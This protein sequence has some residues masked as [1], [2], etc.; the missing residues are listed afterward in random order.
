[1]V[2]NFIVR[3]FKCS[4]TKMKGMAG[5]VSQVLPIGFDGLTII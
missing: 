2:I 3:D 4:G 1:M 5:V